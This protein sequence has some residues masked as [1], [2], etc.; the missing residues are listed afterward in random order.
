MKARY[1]IILFTLAMVVLFVGCSNKESSE[2]LGDNSSNNESNSSNTSNEIVDKEENIANEIRIAANAQP[3]SL[4]PHVTT[5]TI[6]SFI[7]RNM[8]ESLMTLNSDYEPVPM[9]AESV[10]ISDDQLKYSFKLRKGVKFHNGDEMKSEDV[11]A[12]MNRWLE[13]SAIA[14]AALGHDAEFKSED[15]YTVILE[16]KERSSGALYT[17]ATPK[18]IAA[19]Y[20][21]EVIDSVDDSGNITEF[22]GTGP[23]KFEEWKQDQYIHFSKFEEYVGLSEETN[24]MSGGK[25]PQVKNLYFDIVTDASTRLAGLTTGMYDIAMN[26]SP[27]HY[28][29]VKNDPSLE[30]MLLSRAYEILNFNKKQGP[31]IDVNLRKAIATALNIDEIMYGAFGNEDLYEIYSGFM[32]K[33]QSL[34]S[35]VGSEYYNLNNIELAKELL[36]Q[37]NYNYEEVILMSSRDYDHFYQAATIIQEQL[38]EIGINV[39]MEVY[40]WPT[41]LD[42]EHDPESW[43]MEVTGYTTWITPAENIIFN[44]GSPGWTKDPKLDEIIK[45]IKDSTS[46]D[47]L[48]SYYDKLH[49]F[50]L[51]DYVPGVKLG[52][53]MDIYALNKKVKNFEL[54]E[55]MILWN[56]G[57]EE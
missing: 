9:L 4:D 12:S 16:L 23:F 2:T 48:Q 44:E 8:F 18:Q 3:T 57:L 52:N 51:I 39:K 31:L 27:E 53:Y 55:G 6:T 24:G 46:H 15:D 40:D 10:E 13:R 26:I 50:L 19:I 25:N 33:D 29:Q 20:P 47:E 5:G 32:K 30:V 41:F 11:V 54:F 38:K 28:D 7:S 22:I 35:D 45:N 17:M 37:S 49:E 43:D 14:Q 21:K 34:Y 56:V 42:L 1:I 36:E